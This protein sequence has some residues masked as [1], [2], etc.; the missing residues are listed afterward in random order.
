MVASSNGIS[1]LATF[2]RAYFLPPMKGYGIE[3][4]NNLL[5]PKHR[6]RIGTALWEY[7]WC[8]DKM[9]A[10]RSDGI[11]LVM[12]GNVIKLDDLER[13]LGTKGRHISY[14]LHKLHDEGYIRLTRTP[15]GFTIAVAKAHKRFGNKTARKVTSQTAK[16]VSS[17]RKKG[18]TRPQ[19]RLFASIDKTK[20]H[21][22]KTDFANAKEETSYGNEE[23]SELVDHF[24]SVFGFPLTGMTRQR[25]A[26]KVLLVRCKDLPTAKRSIE[27]ALMAS[28]DQYSG[29]RPT[30]LAWLQDT[31]N[32]NKLVSYVKTKPRQSKVG[33]VGRT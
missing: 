5:E 31:R 6:K 8:L 24:Q 33:H 27:A 13:D 20:G 30:E 22:Q 14:S 10:I 29:I 2:G 16:N 19:E 17:D 26:A 12:G 18:N 15:N 9:T 32:W 3:V 4:K 21:T 25:R 11:G 28:T 1:S 7:L 23:I